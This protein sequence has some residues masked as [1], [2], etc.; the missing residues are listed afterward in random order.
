MDEDQTFAVET[1]M[2]RH[3]LVLTGQAG[4][5]KSHVIKE[6]IKQLRET[7]T[8]FSVTASTGLGKEL[9]S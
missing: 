5:G 1:I 7:D 9:Q 4:T 2:K 3:N 6:D 8:R